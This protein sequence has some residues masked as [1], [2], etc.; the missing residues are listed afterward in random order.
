M[1]DAFGDSS[2]IPIKN[3]R[4]II[5][6]KTIKLDE[7]LSNYKKV[8]LVK[9]ESEGAEPEI[10]LGG[11]KNF[12]KVEFISIDVGFERGIDQSSTLVECTNFLLRN[13]F[14]LIDFR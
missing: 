3:C 8:K 12:K 9:I 7:V 2:I 4:K 14:S 13:N 1:S 11:I 10:L 5:N 6:I